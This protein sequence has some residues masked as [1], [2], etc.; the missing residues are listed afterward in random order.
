MTHSELK[1]KGSTSRLLQIINVFLLDFEAQKKP[2]NK[3]LDRKSVFD[4]ETASLRGIPSER[5]VLLK[6]STEFMENKRLHFR[7]L[8][9]LAVQ[10]VLYIS[11]RK[12]QPAMITS[13][14]SGR[15][16]RLA[17]NSEQK[18]DSL[19]YDIIKRGVGGGRASTP[20]KVIAAYWLNTNTAELF[21]KNTIIG[22]K[23]HSIALKLC[24]FTQVW[25]KNCISSEVCPLSQADA[26]KSFFSLSVARQQNINTLSGQ[27]ARFVLF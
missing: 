27:Q 4:N 10:L 20:C 22:K 8:Q 5:D 2:Q 6:A 16:D 23:T 19:V 21:V 17:T 1:E 25:F 11:S 13:H 7:H 3:H 12:W 26:I 15:K 24:I 18:G 9:A 14:F